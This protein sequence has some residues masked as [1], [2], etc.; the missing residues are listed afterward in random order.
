VT[1]WL[2]QR[3]FYQKTNFDDQ[4]GFTA[5]AQKVQQVAAARKSC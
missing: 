5:L 1:R 4:A 3:T 2:A